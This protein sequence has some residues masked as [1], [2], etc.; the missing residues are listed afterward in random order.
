[1]V[2]SNF[3]LMP[4]YRD[5]LN[6]LVLS[7]NTTKANPVI[8]ARHKM[9]LEGLNGSGDVIAYKVEDG[10]KYIKYTE[11]PNYSFPSLLARAE[12]RAVVRALLN[13][14]EWERIYDG[15]ESQ[16]GNVQGKTEDI[17]IEH[18]RSLDKQ[19]KQHLQYALGAAGGLLG[20]YF[21]IK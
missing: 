11:S 8:P 4:V 19:K 2:N 21:L 9:M 6:G 3:G 13:E 7:L 20:L 15:D 12:N 17:A 16:Y 1:M 18:A 14:G 5:G 10:A